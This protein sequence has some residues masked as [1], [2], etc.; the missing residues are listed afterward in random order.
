MNN[1]AQTTKTLA[2]K[3]AQQMQDESLEILK[4]AK[5]QITGKES[6]DN[7]SREQYDPEAQANLLHEQKKA[8]DHAKSQRLLQA[9]QRELEDVR[10]QDLLK[11]LQRRIAE[12]EEVP[13]EDYP[14]LSMEHKQVL[15]AQMEAVR[16]RNLQS[17]GSKPLV[18]PVAKKGRRM[19]NFGKKTSMKR[20]QTRV[21]KVV[22]P[23]G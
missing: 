20:E 13:L 3:I 6:G 7:G 5:E 19:F 18:E 22:P 11:N 21:E 14:E 10:K 9:Y 17:T 1:P 16:A 23:S 12:G 15:R 2:Q 8:Q 4:D